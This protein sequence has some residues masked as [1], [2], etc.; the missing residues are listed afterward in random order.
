[1]QP[2]DILESCLYVDDL[3]AA[4]D[5]YTNVLGLKLHSQVKDRHVFFYCGERMLLLFDPEASSELGGEIPA[6]GAVGPGHLALAV[7]EDQLDEWK[8]RLE[9]SQTPIEVD[10]HWPGGGRSLYFRDPAGNSLELATPKIWG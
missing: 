8:R 3:A 2:D 10:Y 7:A 9:A 5:F 6:H 1:M 4:A